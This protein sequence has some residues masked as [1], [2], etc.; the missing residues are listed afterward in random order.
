MIF[1]VYYKN[2][3]MGEVSAP[4]HEAAE[5][6]VVEQIAEREPETHIDLIRAMIQIITLK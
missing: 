3:F 6:F 5:D 4:T 2:E 1:N